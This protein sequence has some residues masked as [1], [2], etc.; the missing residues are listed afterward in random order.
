MMIDKILGLIILMSVSFVVGY[1]GA[2]EN[3]FHKLGQWFG[4]TGEDKK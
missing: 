3:G 2:T 4:I 1:C